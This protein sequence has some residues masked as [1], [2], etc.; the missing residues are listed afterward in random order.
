MKN[1]VV[2]V[3]GSLS[4]LT[5]ALACSDRGIRTW[6]LERGHEQNQGGGALGVDRSLL[7]RVVG[8]DPDTGCEAEPFPVLTKYRRAVSWRALY[9]WLRDRACRRPEITLLE[10]YSVSEVVQSDVSATAITAE[11]ERI[12]AEVIVGADGYRSV[13]RKA[14]NPEWPAGRYAGYLLWRG[15]VHEAELPSDTRWPQNNNGVALSTQTG[16]RLVAY[17]VAGRDGSLE[18]GERGISFAWYDANRTDLLREQKCLSASDDVLASL[19]PK[20]IPRS[21]LTEL[22]TLAATM[23]PN[24]WRA[25]VIHA[26]DQRE[27][28]ATPVAEYFPKR[29]VNGRLAIIGDA[30]H[31]TSPVTGRGFAAGVLD[32]DLLAKNLVRSNAHDSAG[33]ARALESFESHRL[34]EAQSLA[35][36][37]MAWSQAFVAGCGLSLWKGWKRKLQNKS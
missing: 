29:M 26:I 9:S 33:I 10:G 17:P 22:R 28:F 31:V 30:A 35:E 6:V 24:P 4:G 3:G 25:G 21:V 15:L 16:F 5:F 11:G 2:I 1:D 14:V 19:G 27:I 37:S 7:L 36:T 23:W 18:P 8:V 13:V 34:P 32:A 20:D 12:D